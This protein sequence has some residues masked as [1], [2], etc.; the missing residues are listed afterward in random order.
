MPLGLPVA[1]LINVSLSLSSAIAGF[2]NLNSTVLMGESDV[3][4][5]TQRI[6][7]FSSLS[8]IGSAF[9]S[10]SPEYLAAQSYFSQ[11]PPPTTVYIGRWAHTAGAGRLIGI[12]LNAQQQQ[13]SNFNTITAG[14]FHIQFNGAGPGYDVRNINLTGATNLN[15]VA[16][17]IQ[18]AMRGTTGVGACT[19]TWDGSSFHLLGPNVGAGFTVQP[20]TDAAAPAHTYLGPLLGL[21]T[22]QNPQSHPGFAAESLLQAVQA[23]DQQATY[24][25]ALNTDACP[26]A[27]PSD[28]EAVAAYIEASAANSLPH[29]YCFTCQDP[30]ATVPTA[31]TDVGAVLNASGYERTFVQY[32]STSKYA[33]CSEI[34]LFMTVNL[35]GNNTMISA[36]YKQE[37]GITPESLSTNA[38]N[39]LDSKGYNYYA[40]FNNGVPVLVNACMICTEIFPGGGA[41]EVY[42]DEI[43]GADGLANAIQTDYFNLMT[44]VSKLPQ[45]DA[46]SH[47][48]ATAIESACDQFV[49]NG[50]LGPGVWNATGF[51]QIATGSFLPKGYYVYTPPI[52]TQPQAARAARQSVPYQVAAKTAGAIHTAY[53]QV[54][55]NP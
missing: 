2:A 9:G 10:T 42:I 41:D 13:I 16:S 3:I 21:D 31:T 26:D 7:A 48:G 35:E 12:P 24:Y 45:T 37:P 29:I 46:G 40:M 1:R 30:N 20:M 51:G 25:Y 43:F 33:A 8:A 32:S 19:V 14:A 36:A 34:A 52:A 15:A 17:I 6:E 47:L 22:A 18:T 50:Y 4:D 53:I 5:T 39:S 38:A 27:Q 55:V 44:S 23:L 49:T 54:T 28:N 11:S